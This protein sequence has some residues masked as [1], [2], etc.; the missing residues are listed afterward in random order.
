M[1]AHFAMTTSNELAIKARKGDHIQY[2]IAIEWTIMEKTSS[3]NL[4]CLLD[5]SGNGADGGNLDGDESGDDDVIVKTWFP[6]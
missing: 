2:C 6:P 4:G 3:G 1:A 5:E